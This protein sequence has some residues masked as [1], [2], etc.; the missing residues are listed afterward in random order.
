MFHIVP[1]KATHSK[2]LA[3]RSLL[4]ACLEHT[5]AH[6]VA[7]ASLCRSGPQ[8]PDVKPRNLFIHRRQPST[9]NIFHGREVLSSLWAKACH[10]VDCPLWRALAYASWGEALLVRA[11]ANLYAIFPTFCKTAD[12]E[13]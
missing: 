2:I 1:P 13:K 11:L 6:V 12:V 5:A 7:L 3:E 8:L 10:V 4:H 9:I